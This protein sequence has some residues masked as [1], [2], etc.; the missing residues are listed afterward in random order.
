MRRSGCLA[1]TPLALA[2]GLAFAVGASHA[3]VFRGLFDAA[4]ASDPTYRAARLE[5]TSSGHGTDIARAGLLP[6]ATLSLSD[7][8]VSGSRTAV[9]IF[10]QTVTSPLDYR[11]PQQVLSVRAP[12]LNRDAQQKLEQARAQQRVAEAVLA[13]RGQELVERLAQAMLQRLFADNQLDAV[14]VQLQTAA[15]RRQMAQR[16]L[17]LGEGTRP[18]LLAAEADLAAA[19]VQRIEAINQRRAAD[20]ALQQLTG[21]DPVQGPALPGVLREA[22]FD[23]PMEI[24][25]WAAR[26]GADNLAIQ[27]RH[28]QVEVARL[29]IARAEAGHHPRLDLVASVSSSKNES[30]STL[31]QSVRQRSLGLQLN[32]P[33]YNGGGVVAATSQG[34]ADLEKSQADLE[35]EQLS[36]A[37]E[38]Q[39]LV[40][41]LEGAPARLDALQM[42][43]DASRLALEGVRRGATGGIRAP[44]DLDLAQ[45]KVAEA[46]RD[47][48]RALYEIALNRIR[49]QSRSGTSAEAL[50]DY[51]D[52]LLG[53]PAPRV[54]P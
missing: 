3:G 42:A 51:V 17:D 37:A 9:N 46:L 43:V 54:R 36:V 8:Q 11:T 23:E 34:L 25:R 26:A 49:L 40:L 33:L 16:R 29:A 30:V 1:V 44:A 32:I 52:T 50:A 6:S 12:L 48:A 20:L 7:A 47:Q 41:V 15:T 53:G 10:G 27:I 21:R 38:V 5:A 18:E 45:Q 19:Q 4:Q 22:L 35:A 14:Q 31:N 24:V 39:R 28:R 13:L 2:V